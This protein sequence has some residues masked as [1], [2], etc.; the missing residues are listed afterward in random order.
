MNKTFCLMLA[1]L[2]AG[3][4]SGGNTGFTYPTEDSQ[5]SIQTESPLPNQPSQDLSPAEK[6]AALEAEKKLPKLDRNYELAGVDEDNNGIR[7]DI[8]A[9]IQENYSDPKQSAAA[10]QFARSMQSI[11]LADPEDMDQVRAARRAST[12][13]TYC[14]YRT[15]DLK[16]GVQPGNVSSTIEAMTTNTK[17]RIK[18]Y[19][20]FHKSL[21]GTSWGSPEGDTCE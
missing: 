9:Y 1:M 12:R 18:A 13:A 8:D 10:A 14:L 4:D 2:L 17:Q 19:F 16:I 3:C 15:F 5:E 11:I 21:D 7:D 6:L 20:R